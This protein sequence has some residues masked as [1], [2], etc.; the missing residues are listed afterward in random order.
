MFGHEAKKI[1]LVRED[2]GIVRGDRLVNPMLAEFAAV[3]VV[4]RVAG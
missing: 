1:R 3:P 2:L 4:D